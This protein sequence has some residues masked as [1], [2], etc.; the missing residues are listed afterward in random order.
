MKSVV[1][2]AAQAPF[3]VGGA[4]IL[5]DRVRQRIAP[6]KCNTD[7]WLRVMEIGHGLGR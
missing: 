6:R 2:C 7:S 4:E 3:I 1:I 5:V